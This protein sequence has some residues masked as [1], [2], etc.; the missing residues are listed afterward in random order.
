MPRPYIL[1]STDADRFPAAGEFC[2]K[3]PFAGT[4]S[5]PQEGTIA[6]S[7]G[8]LLGIILVNAGSAAR[9]CRLRPILC[10]RTRRR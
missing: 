6:D 8:L 7:E 1:V 10:S 2:G 5:I 4:G 3:P 9:T